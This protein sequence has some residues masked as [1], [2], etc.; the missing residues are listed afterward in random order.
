MQ[1]YCAPMESLTGY[2]FRNA[3]QALFPGVD[4]YYAPFVSPGQ[5]RCFTAREANDLLPEHNEGIPPVPQLL[6]NRAED[7]LWAAEALAE[8]G[9]R[10]VNLNLGCPS[11]TVTAKGKGAGFLSHLDLLDAFL[12]QIFAKSPVAV[13]IKTRI[14]KADPAEFERILDVYCRYPLS[15]LIVHPRLQADKYR[16]QPRMEAFERALARCPFPVGY[17]GDL[18]S[19]AQAREWAGQYPAA[20]S[21]MFGRG[22]IANPALIRQIQTGAPLKKAELKRFYD[23]LCEGYLAVLPGEKTLLFRMKEHCLYMAPLFA[24]AEKHVKREKKATRLNEY[25]DAVNRLFDECE[26]APDAAFIPP[27]ASR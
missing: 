24:D 5:N 23:R 14:G 18:F 13:S 26:L 9:Y 25:V 11:G 12:E 10:E 17:N 3:H 19:A 8:M 21:A 27:G 16:G 20:H 4:R 1:L 22:L 6:T 15:E 2:V 7:F